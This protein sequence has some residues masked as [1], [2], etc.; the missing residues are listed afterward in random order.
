MQVLKIFV[1]KNHQ[2][3][4]K[5]ERGYDHDDDLLGDSSVDLEGDDDDLLEGDD[6]FLD[7]DVIEEDMLGNSHS[8]RPE[9]HF[10]LDQK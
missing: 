8:Q 3:C 4:F 5:F 7:D 6:D 2:L 9:F 1:S 10:A